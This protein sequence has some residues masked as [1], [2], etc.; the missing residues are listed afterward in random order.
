M[1]AEEVGPGEAGARIVREPALLGRLR[2]DPEPGAVLR[3]MRALSRAVRRSG[4]PDDA[5]EPQSVVRLSER[6]AAFTRAEAATNAPVDWTTPEGDRVTGR[7]EVE[8]SA[9]SV[10]EGR[11]REIDKGEARLKELGGLRGAEQR[12]QRSLDGLSPRQTR[13]VVERLGGARPALD[14]AFGV[15]RRTVE[16]GR[17][18]RTL[19]E[20]PAGI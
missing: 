18:A 20:G 5:I 10:A 13:E 16:A 9:R 2:S 6:A 8:R 3:A 15:V 7:A 12:A 14:R 1:L 4:Q 11:Q 19:G 17:L